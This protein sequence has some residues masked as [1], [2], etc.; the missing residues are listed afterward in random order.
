MAKNSI[1]NCEDPYYDLVYAIVRLAREDLLRANTPH[2]FRMSALRFF[3]SDT[4]VSYTN[5]DGAEIAYQLV[6]T[7]PDG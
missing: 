3:L 5:L 6:E 2:L 1:D 4:F 7:L